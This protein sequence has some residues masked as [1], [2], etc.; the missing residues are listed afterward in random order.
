MNAVSGYAIDTVCLVGKETVK[1]DFRLDTFYNHI[2][3]SSDYI[4]MRHAVRMMR[5]YVSAIGL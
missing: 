4:N 5:L 3:L 2:I 1:D